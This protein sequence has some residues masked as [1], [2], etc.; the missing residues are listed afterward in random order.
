TMVGGTKFY[1]RKEIRDV[2]SYLNIIANPSEN[3]SY[4]SIVNEPKRGVGPGTVEKLRDFET[5]HSISLLEAS[6]DSMLS[7]MKG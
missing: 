7:P 4:E 1:S 2:N 3:I 6:Q 5:S